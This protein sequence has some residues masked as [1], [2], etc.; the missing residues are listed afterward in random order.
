MG[1][2]N[3]VSE[4][5]SFGAS[6]THTSDISYAFCNQK[7]FRHIYDSSGPYSES[8]EYGP[9]HHIQIFKELL[10]VFSKPQK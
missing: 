1:Q 5:R 7:F 3:S 6:R 8:A 2:N 10:N 4:S 9:R